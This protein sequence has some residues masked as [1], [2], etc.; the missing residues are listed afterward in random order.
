MH[1]KIENSI[2]GYKSTYQSES[3]LRHWFPWIVSIL[4][5]VLIPVGSWYIYNAAENGDV[6][7]MPYPLFALF[8][9]LIFKMYSLIDRRAE[10]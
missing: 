4:V 7:W 10:D 8:V 3:K 6:S 2:S 5:C 1:G 9:A